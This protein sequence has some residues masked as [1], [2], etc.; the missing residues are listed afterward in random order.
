MTKSKR[1]KSLTYDYEQD[2]P[3]NLAAGKA[4]SL[5]NVFRD[6]VA[7]SSRGCLL[8]TEKLSRAELTPLAEKEMKA[9]RDIAYR[10]AYV[11]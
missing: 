1:Q 7:S 5:T 10:T 4:E 3:P 9:H 11:T 2:L 6:K 8:F